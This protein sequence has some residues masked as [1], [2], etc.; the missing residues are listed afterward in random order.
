MGKGLTDMATNYARTINNG[1]PV[2]SVSAKE[3][4]QYV[5]DVNIYPDQK[6]FGAEY[7]E[8]ILRVNGRVIRRMSRRQALQLGMVTE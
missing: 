5:F 3:I 7:D 8:Y 2:G 1:D 4:R 6:T